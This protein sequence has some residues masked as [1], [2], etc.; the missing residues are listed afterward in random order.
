MAPERRG[1]FL[2]LGALL[3]VTALGSWGCCSV[4]CC[5]KTAGL[6]VV[7]PTGEADPDPIVISKRRHQEIL[8]KL[9]AGSTFA[10]V[11]ITL[12]RNPPPFER[13]ETAEG[14][15]RIACQSGFCSSGPISEAV[16]PP[17]EYKYVFQGPT[18]EVSA[19]PIIRIDP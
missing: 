18:G 7:S 5:D 19:D 12:D 13:C 8:W 4:R 14:V 10:S 17:V 2:V 16:V 9:S 15:C 1:S 3:T 6:V 11:A